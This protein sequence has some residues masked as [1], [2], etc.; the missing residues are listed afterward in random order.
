MPLSIGTQIDTNRIPVKGMIAEQSATALGTPVEGLF[1]HD[2]ANKVVKIYLNGSWMTLGAAGQSVADGDKGEITVASGGTVWTV[3]AGVITDT[4][5]AAANKDGVAGT[6]SMR[7]LGTGATQAAA[8]NDSRF[9]DART[10]TGT[11]GGDLTGSYPNPTVAAGKITATKLDATTVKLNTIAVP[12]GTVDMSGFKI[13]N[14]A[15][16]TTGLDAA[17]K[18]YVDNLAQGLD[19]KASVKAASTGNLTLSGT[20][21]VDGIAL[22][23]GDRVLVKDQSTASANGIYVV[24]SGAWTRA[25]DMDIWAEV[26][27]AFTFVE[28]GT[29]YAD[30][31]WLCSADQGGTL[32]TTA[33]TWAQFSAAGQVIDGAGLIKNGNTLD[34]N[35]DGQTIDVVGDVLKVKNLGINT[36]QIQPGAI[37]AASGI[38]ANGAVDLTTK[39]TGALPIG[40]GG[41]GATTAAAA[42]TNLGA[43]GKYAA[44]LGALTAGAETVITHNLGSSDVIAAFRDA[45]TNYEIIF[46]W[47]V[48]ST[49]QI[50]ITSDI[51]YAANAVKVTVVG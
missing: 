30:T 29:N 51:G 49:T 44:T 34:I 15:D 37:T 7:T 27:G 50:G 11:A 26:P 46:G 19:A 2:T 21:T 48:I 31:G 23:L 12:S 8:G 3:D 41:T 20:Q 5:V 36:P 45:S 28:S 47:R 10:P 32:G 6:A 42:R 25:G 13:A 35:Y 43:V 16:P 18:Q 14:L 22:A 40:N 38:L 4:K 39:V 33:I 17:N 9:T 24:A 1:W